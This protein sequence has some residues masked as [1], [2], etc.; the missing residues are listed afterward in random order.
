MIILDRAPNQGWIVR[1]RRAPMN[2]SETLA[3]FSTTE[4]LIE[5]IGVMADDV[6]P[7][8]SFNIERV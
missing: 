2:E 8:P 3:A 5:W 7:V 6:C 1:R 4:E